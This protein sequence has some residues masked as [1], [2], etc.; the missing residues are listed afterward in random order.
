MPLSACYRFVELVARSE[1]IEDIGSIIGR[2]ASSFDLGAFGQ[3]L[4]GTSTVYDYLR[5]GMRT[6]ESLSSGGTR[7]WLTTEGDAMRVNQCLVGPNSL[8]SDIA[9]VYTLVLTISMLRRMIGPH[10][11]PEDVRLRAGCEALLGDWEG[12]AAGT[13][14]TGQPHSSFTLSQAFLAL[15]VTYTRNGANGG[16]N[17]AASAIPAMPFGFAASVE[18]LIMSLLLDGYTDIDST[19]DAAGMSSRSLQRRLAEEGLTYRSLLTGCRMRQARTRLASVD[20]P[21]ADIAHELGY[22]DASNFA[23][24]FQR[25]NGVSPLDYRRSRLTVA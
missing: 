17:A 12:R 9:D 24:A 22:T 19:A 11:W 25:E 2:H 6:V 14:L 13:L 20:M 1:R 7:F 21:V 18:Q 3:V 23:R 16:D 5:T 4:R 10:W 15:P 8:G